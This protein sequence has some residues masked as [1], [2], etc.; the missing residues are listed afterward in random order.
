MD[1]AHNGPRANR[2]GERCGDEAV[3]EAG[4]AGAA[5]VIAQPFSKVIEACVDVDDLADDRTERHR[6]DKHHRARRGEANGPVF[7]NGGDEHVLE[8]A[9]DANE[10]DADAA[11]AEKRV[12]QVLRDE[13]ACGEADESADNDEDD[14]DEGTE[15]GYVAP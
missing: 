13:R 6:D 15:T 4:I 3:D 10:Y 7:R 14:V 1:G 8:R 12:L 2:E 5:S 11:C 9:C